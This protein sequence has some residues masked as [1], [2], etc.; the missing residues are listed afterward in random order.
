MQ[1][2]TGEPGKTIIKTMANEKSEKNENPAETDILIQFRQRQYSNQEDGFENISSSQNPVL[3]NP[4]R[5]ETDFLNLESS[6]DTNR[7]LDNP[8]AVAVGWQQIYA[9]DTII[10][11]VINIIHPVVVLI[12]ILVGYVIQYSACFQR[13]GISHENINGTCKNYI[14]SEYIIP[15]IFHLLAYIVSFIMLRSAQSEHLNML[16]QKVFLFTTSSDPSGLKKHGKL[17]RTLTYLFIAGLIW[18]ALSTGVCVIQI[19][20]TYNDI[21]F[22]F[23]SPEN[24]TGRFF[25]FILLVL[26]FIALDIIYMAVIIN[27]CLQAFLITEFIDA[28]MERLRKGTLQMTNALKEANEVTNILRTINEKTALALSLV[29]LNF[30]LMGVT[31]MLVLFG[32]TKLGHVQKLVAFLNVIVW[33]SG[34]VP[35]F[36]MV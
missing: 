32:D 31:S 10:A 24:K 22:S 30:L 15:D 13:S 2:S 33:F 36:I 29:L 6:S 34:A 14:I 23:L 16:I 4:S 11:K 7:D 9:R 35:P 5:G 3:N 27:Y 1:W 19:V 18:I 8:T 12:V 28:I 17:I 25:L 20:L 21:P 26:S